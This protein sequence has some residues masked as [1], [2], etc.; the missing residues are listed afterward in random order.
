MAVKILTT[1]GTLTGSSGTWYGV[2]AS[3]STDKDH[4]DSDDLNTSRT[5]AVTF[6]NNGNQLGIVLMLKCTNVTSGVVSI[7]LQEQTSPGVWTARTTDTFTVNSTVFPDRNLIKYFALTSY[8]VTTAADT[9]RYVISCSVGSRIYWVRSGT[10]SDW[11]YWAVLDAVTTAPSASDIVLI[12]DGV[13]LTVDGSLSLGKTTG[14]LSVI[15]CAD[16]ILSWENPPVSSYTLTLAGGILIGYSGGIKIGTAANPITAANKA[17]IDF[18]SGTGTL[19]PRE[20]TYNQSS[21]QDWYLEFYGAKCD[22]IAVSVAANAATGQKNIVTTRDMSAIWSNGDAISIVGKAKTGSD[23]VTYTIDSMSGTTITLN[24]NLDAG[25]LAGGR[26]VNLNERDNLGVW[27]KGNNTEMTGG[28]YNF[29]FYWG[30]SKFSGVYSQNLGLG[31]GAATQF[32]GPRS[33]TEDELYESILIN[34]PGGNNECLALPNVSD[35]TI[36]N[37]HIYSIRT[38]YNYCVIANGNNITINGL[39]AKGMSMASSMAFTLSGNN[40]SVTDV[41]IGYGNSGAGSLSGSGFALTDCYFFSGTQALSITLNASTFTNVHGNAGSSY[42]LMSLNSV[43]VQGSNCG[44]GDGMAAGTSDI[45]ITANYLA[46]MIF[47]NSKVG[48][49]GVGGLTNAINTSYVKMDT[50]G[51]TANDHRSWFKYGNIISTGDGLT[52]TTVHTAGTGKFAIR[53]EPLSSA[54]NLEWEYDVPTGNIQNKTMTVAVW[55]KLNSATYYAGTHQLP[56]LTIDYD[57]GTTAYSQ[58]AESTDWQQLFVTFVPTTTYGQITVTLSG[59]TD[60]TTT[61]AYVYFDDFALLYPA[62]NSLDLG[63]MDN[64]ADA[65]PVTP[66]V[67]LPIGAYAVSAAVWEELKASHT[68]TGTMGEWLGKLLDKITFWGTK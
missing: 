68:T 12:A 40:N 8:A 13:T 48:T 57:N 14:N 10:A 32:G 1:S 60:A 62:N 5:K 39:T 52:D 17:I 50:Y 2:E 33:T 56:R 7:V 26:L 51:T 22:D 11:Q 44:F 4:D 64:W 34:D 54:T 55:V 28:S 3:N 53:F 37:V 36:T 18:S 9:W 35:A 21:A 19:F 15:I 16:A 67:A 43:D 24:A 31:F 49:A 47:K 41:S 61:N 66:P 6:G 30:Y 46:R 45:F 38:P 25:V 59:R 27:L 42:N 58:A 23:S 29:G 65:L 63:G 20:T